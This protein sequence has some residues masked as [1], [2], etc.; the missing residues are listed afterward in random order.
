MTL[1]PSNMNTTILQK[2]LDILNSEAPD[3]SRVKGIL[4]TL[5][6][7]SSQVQPPA[8]PYLM[9]HM[10]Q[11]TPITPVTILNEPIPVEHSNIEDAYLR[12]G[13]ATSGLQP[14]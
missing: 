11:Q 8:N 2:C 4:E 3:L 6:E 7:M 9:P 13:I 5:I 10:V 1:L 14:S 12:G